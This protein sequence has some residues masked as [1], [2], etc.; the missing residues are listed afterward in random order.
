MSIR[1]ESL[2]LLNAEVAQDRAGRRAFANTLLL[3]SAVILISPIVGAVLEE[4]DVVVFNHHANKVF[5]ASFMLMLLASVPTAFAARFIARKRALAASASIA[6]GGGDMA[7]VGVMGN[8]LLDAEHKDAALRQLRSDLWRLVVGVSLV[9]P[10]F[11]HAVVFGF[12]SL[13]AGEAG[14]D[15]AQG[16]A[17]YMAIS[18]VIVGHAHLVVIGIGMRFVHRLVLEGKDGSAAFNVFMA[19]LAGCIPGALFMMIPPIFVLITGGLFIPV[20]YAYIRGE[21]KRERARLGLDT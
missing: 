20:M 5:G 17:G 7:S 3:M 16:F 6:G 11:I 12:F 14:L 1:R 13:A 10:L 8:G 4:L 15:T 21:V 18:A 9:A 19:A 2:V